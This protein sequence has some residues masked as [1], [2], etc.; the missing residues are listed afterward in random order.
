MANRTFQHPRCIT[1]ELIYIEGKFTTDGSGAVGTTTGKGFS[2]TKPAGSGIYRI[3]LEDVYN[4]I[5]SVRPAIL[6]SAV[7]DARVQG[8]VTDVA[9][10]NKKVDL[11][12]YEGVDDRQLPYKK[13]S[14]DGAA[15][16]ATAE[17]MIG[18]TP[19]AAT[20]ES[21]HYCPDAALTAHDTDYATLTL[22]KRASGGGSQ[23]KVAEQ[24]TKITGG[25]GNWTQYAP[26]NIPVVAGALVAGDGLLFQIA[27]AGAGVVVPAGTLIVK[28]TDIRGLDLI[29][30]EVHFSLALVNTDTP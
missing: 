8:Q 12:V 3:T 4:A 10:T 28:Y 24:T 13:D 6:K 23:V 1:R 22:W 27:K 15:N 26:V 16:T 5:H 17:H 30:G 18:R 25:S 7:H 21:V 9:T 20:V 29:S 2:V 19:N 11:Q 14:A